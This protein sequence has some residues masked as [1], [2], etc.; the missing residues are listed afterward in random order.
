MN[1]TPLRASILPLA[2]KGKEVSSIAILHG[3]RLVASAQL[4]GRYDEAQA[5]NEYRRNP[6]LFRRK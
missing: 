4:G 2:V 6:Q 1:Q 3:K 5:L